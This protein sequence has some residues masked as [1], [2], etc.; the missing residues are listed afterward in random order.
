MKCPDC[1]G[2]TA[3]IDSRHIDSPAKTLTRASRET[4][5][6]LVGWYTQDWIIRTRACRLCRR[7]MR[8]IEVYAVDFDAIIKEKQTHGQ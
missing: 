4:A 7:R 8:S 6:R 5:E 1:D 2:D 3:I